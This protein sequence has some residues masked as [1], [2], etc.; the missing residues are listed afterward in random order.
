[1]NETTRA[2]G[3]KEHKFY[4]F[5]RENQNTKEYENLHWEGS[6]AEYL[7]IVDKNPKA[8]ASAFERIYN[9]I[10]SYGVEEYVDVRKKLFRYPFFQDPFENGKDSVYGLDIPLMR[11]VN[12]FK[13]AA[14]RYGTEKRVMLLHGPVGSSKSTIVR[15][16]KKGMERYSQI[17]EGALYT[18]SWRLTDDIKSEKITT[19]DETDCPMHEEP[20]H[21]IPSE[22][23]ASILE[24]LNEGKTEEKR[25]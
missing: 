3:P 19:E 5:I 12:V 13:S 17:P 21:L 16:L 22:L 18:F 20:L 11:L 2:T 9:M 23:R 24:K 25:I 15:L 10:V 8:T 6:F 1:M 7:D 4:K 14:K